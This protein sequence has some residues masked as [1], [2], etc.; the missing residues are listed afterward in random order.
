MHTGTRPHTIQ[1]NIL[2]KVAPKPPRIILHSSQED[3]QNFLSFCYLPW[4][5]KSTEYFKLYLSLKKKK[6][7]MESWL[8]N[9]LFATYDLVFFWLALFLLYYFGTVLINFNCW[10]W[11]T[12]WIAATLSK[13]WFWKCSRNHYSEFETKG[14][15]FR[16]YILFLGQQNNSYILSYLQ[17]LTRKY[18]TTLL[19]VFL[20]G[21]G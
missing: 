20:V 18:L 11:N 3:Q 13:Y 2:N 5:Q 6:G 8:P 19:V 1:V 21:A 10:E 9:P 12:T 16:I 14:S 7:Q 15:S 4:E 17:N